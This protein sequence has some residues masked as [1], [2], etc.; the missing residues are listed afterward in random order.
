MRIYLTDL[1]NKNGL[2]QKDVSSRLG[3]SES[4][5]NLIEHGARQKDMS[6]IL[7]LG[8]S[9]IFKVSLKSLIDKEIDFINRR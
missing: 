6:V 1:R 9:Q 4:Y 7:L 3:I 5:Y 2:T 8:L